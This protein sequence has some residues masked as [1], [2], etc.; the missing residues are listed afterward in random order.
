MPESN[1]LK[2][3]KYLYPFEHCT[4]ILYIP[5]KFIWAFSTT[6]NFGPIILLDYDI[7]GDNMNEDSLGNKFSIQRRRN[8]K[9]H[10]WAT[11]T[12]LPEKNSLLQ[13][14][15]FK[16]MG[17]PR[18]IG[19]NWR[20]QYFI[21]FTAIPSIKQ[22][23]C[24]LYHNI[25]LREVIVVDVATLLKYTPLL[26]MHYQNVYHLE[27]PPLGI[28]RSEEWYKIDC[29]PSECCYLL[30]IVGKNVS[31]LSKY[32]WS[33]TRFSDPNYNKTLQVDID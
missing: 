19:E 5:N 16:L 20:S 6:P 32:F 15:F 2:F 23:L 10:C 4:T 28:R 26:E 27:T 8:P 24:H 22:Y 13:E 33:P 29:L 3:T 12:M 18:V 17:L 11:F 14:R 31:K 9:H 21:L 25:R 7:K 1:S 30:N